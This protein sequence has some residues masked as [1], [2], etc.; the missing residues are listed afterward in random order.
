MHWPILGKYLKLDGSWGVKFSSSSEHSS[1]SDAKRSCLN[2]GNC[3]GIVSPSPESF[4]AATYPIAICWGSCQV[5]DI[6][7]NY[8]EVYEKDTSI[9]TSSQTYPLKIKDLYKISNMIKQS[10][11]LY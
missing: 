1:L 8:Y 5:G 7:A 2:R 6:T 10:T 9:G 4:M 11:F 3:F